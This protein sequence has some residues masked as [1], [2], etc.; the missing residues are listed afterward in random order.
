MNFS[1]RRVG[2]MGAL[3][4]LFAVCHVNA[5][6]QDNRQRSLTCDN[7]WNGDRAHHCEIR[8]QTLAATGRLS[9]DPG[10]N[11]GTTIK[12]WLE[13][14]VL[15]RARVETWAETDSEAASLAP[16]IRVDAN[17][18]QVTASGPDSQSANGRNNTGWSVSY[19]IFVPQ[20]S[21]LDL[22]ANN[23]GITISDVRGRV[24][25]TAKNGGVTL[26]RVAGDVS[27]STLNG[28]LH[29]ELAGNTWDGRQLEV[30]TTNGGITLALPDV[31]S[32]HLRTE[33]VNGGVRSEHPAVTLQP[34][35]IGANGRRNQ[36][37]DVNLG[38]GGALIHVSTINGGITVKRL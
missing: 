15:V 9:V 23:G 28:G 19:E 20:V 33:T 16:Q 8:E 29:V 10:R 13:N 27:G 12:G 7:A 24:Q 37:I 38:S 2:C 26:R 3:V 21:D 36:N 18:G 14:Q 17:T 1:V 32:A 34:A 25:F 11:G 31:Y 6:M 35:S 5:Q 22:K 4:G 30:S